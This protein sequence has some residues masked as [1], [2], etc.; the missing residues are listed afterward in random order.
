MKNAFGLKIIVPALVL[1]MALAAP[2]LAATT[3]S[4]PVDASGPK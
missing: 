2:A 1:G 4:Q 3:I